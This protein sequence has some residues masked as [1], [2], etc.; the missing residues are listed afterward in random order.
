MQLAVIMPVFKK[1]FSTK[2]GKLVDW[3][4]G[5]LVTPDSNDFKYGEFF[6]PEILIN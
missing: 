5:E 1:S 6:K 2:S 3:L 4:I